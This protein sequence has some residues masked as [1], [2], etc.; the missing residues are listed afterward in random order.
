LRKSEKNRPQSRGRSCCFIKTEL[1]TDGPDVTDIVSLCSHR[2]AIAEAQAR[3]VQSTEN[4]EEP[5][6][7]DVAAAVVVGVDQF[8]EFLLEADAGLVQAGQ[9][10]V[11][12]RSWPGRSRIFEWGDSK[13]LS[14]FSFFLG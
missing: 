11:T 4:V 9:A 13:A 3:N 12:S 8:L 14:P 1:T 5:Q 10:V 7:L 6:F 2:G